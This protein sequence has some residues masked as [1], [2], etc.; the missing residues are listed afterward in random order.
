[1]SG[2]P[3][4]PIQ[5]AIELGRH[6]VSL[7]LQGKQEEAAFYYEKAANVLQ[8]LST[9]NAPLAEKWSNKA[10]E[11]KQRAISIRSTV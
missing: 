11:Y 5:L 6:A 8:E 1:M 7:D 4:E 10:S 3:Q 2:P 9:S